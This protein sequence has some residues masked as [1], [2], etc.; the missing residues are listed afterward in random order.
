MISH[1]IDQEE[2]NARKMS[3]LFPHLVLPRLVEIH[4]RRVGLELSWKTA[5]L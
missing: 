1:V 2:V 5:R 4:M 3:S